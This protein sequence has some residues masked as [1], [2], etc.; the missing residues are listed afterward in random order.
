MTSKFDSWQACRLRDKVSESNCKAELFFPLQGIASSPAGLGGIGLKS[1]DIFKYRV[2]VT[3]LGL[4]LD[5]SKGQ[6]V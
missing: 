5:H 2:N 3:G 6:E 1:S 4:K